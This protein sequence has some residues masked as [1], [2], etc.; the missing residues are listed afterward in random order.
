MTTSVLDGVRDEGALTVGIL[1]SYP[2]YCAAV[3]IRYEEMEKADGEVHFRLCS[4]FS[5]P[6]LLRGR[7]GVASIMHDQLQWVP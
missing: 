4:C 7:E 6:L 3:Q 5:R 1:N 2:Y